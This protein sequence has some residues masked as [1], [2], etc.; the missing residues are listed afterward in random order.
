MDKKP[1]SP[2][3]AVAIFLVATLYFYL[4]L[5]TLFPFLKANFSVH[6]AVYW[7]VTGYFLFVPL[8]AY[9]LILVRAEG[10][11][12]MREIMLSLNIRPF[13]KHEWTYSII[14]LVIVCVSS[15]LVFWISSW[16]SS[17]L[18]FGSLDTT[19]WFM[20]MEPFHGA[21]RLLL[22]VWL[23]MFFFNIVGEEML[24]RGYIQ[25]RLRGERAWVLCSFLWLIF[26]LPFGMGVLLLALPAIVVIPYIFHKTHNTLTGIFIH[27][28]F[29]GPIFVAIALGLID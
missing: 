14:G 1:V 2:L 23:P 16:V 4:L 10:N 6:P 5:F 12:G 24:W 29:N 17:R 28:L 19:P 21:E 3:K 9:A 27:G 11:R 7:F 15:G 13:K 18:G 26:H 8:F 22:L 25:T 20:E